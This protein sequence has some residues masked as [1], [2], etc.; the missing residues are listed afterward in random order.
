MH[1][2]ATLAMPLIESYSKEDV[3]RLRS[4][5]GDEGIIWRALKVGIV[6]VDVTE[7]VP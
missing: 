6:K 3:C 7:A 1:S 2:C 5:I 4:A